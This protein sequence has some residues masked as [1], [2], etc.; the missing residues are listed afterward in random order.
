MEDPTL[1]TRPIEA[2]DAASIAEIY[3]PIVE[4]TA[5]SFEAIPPDEQEM[6]ERIR[7]NV[8]T[9]PWLVAEVKSQVVGYAYASRYRAR[10]AYR[11]STESSVYIRDGFRGQGI[12]KRLYQSLFEVLKALGYVS[13]YAGFTLPN[14]PSRNAH[15]KMGFESIGVFRNAGFKFGQWHD[16]E[17]TQLEL[18]TPEVNPQPP[19]PWRKAKQDPAIV[20]S[21]N[22]SS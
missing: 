10:A 21:I 20:G 15:L 14:E 3:A 2:S 11:W 12:A 13:V 8:E 22:S 1:T 18:R 4:S 5:I 17:W 6:A 19:V 9:H 16:V 7:A